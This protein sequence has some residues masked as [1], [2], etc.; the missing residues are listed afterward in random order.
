MSELSWKIWALRVAIS[1]ILTSASAGVISFYV[2]DYV[3]RANTSSTE[4]TLSGLDGSL[5]RLSSALEAN[6]NRIGRSLDGTTKAVDRLQGQLSQLMVQ[7]A[8]QTGQLAS[9]ETKVTKISDAVQKSGIDI[10][11]SD[12]PGKLPNI[13]SWDDMKA[14]YGLEDD[15]PLFLQVQK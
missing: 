12:L 2:A 1:F 14:I 15:S 9:L 5:N 8:E 6:S 7:S 4:N 3:V 10:Q 13:A 11:I